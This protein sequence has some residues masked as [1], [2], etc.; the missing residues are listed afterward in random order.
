MPESA[1][2]ARGSL[3]SGDPALVRSHARVARHDAAITL[4]GTTAERITQVALEDDLAS[5]PGGVSLSGSGS[6]PGSVP[7]PAWRAGAAEVARSCTGVD[8]TDRTT[9]RRG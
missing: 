8:G 1:P 4:C 9:G 7:A 2:P 3:G 5:S 6:V